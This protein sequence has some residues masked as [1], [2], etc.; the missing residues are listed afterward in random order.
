MVPAV[1]RPASTLRSLRSRALVG[2]RRLRAIGILALALESGPG[3]APHHPA[4][5]G[6]L[7]LDLLS[8]RLVTLSRKRLSLLPGTGWGAGL[9][10]RRRESL[11][12]RPESDD[13]RATRT[14]TVIGA[15]PC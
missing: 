7:A 13:L 15:L 5:P 14:R 11:G 3:R 10:T 6:Q 2:G 8:G 9:S 1:L 12:P 4:G